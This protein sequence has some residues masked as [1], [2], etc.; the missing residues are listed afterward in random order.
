MNFKNI[1][2]TVRNIV[3][4]VWSVSGVVIALLII[5]LPN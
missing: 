4:A 2:W 3:I 5:I 1:K